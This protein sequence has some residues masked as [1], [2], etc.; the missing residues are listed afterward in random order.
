MNQ[1]YQ[2]SPIQYRKRRKQR[3]LQ[4]LFPIKKLPWFKSLWFRGV[5]LS[6]VFISLFTGLI[7]GAPATY[8][9]GQVLLGLSVFISLR[10][11]ADYPLLNPIQ[12]VIAIFYWWFGVGPMVVSSYKALVAFLED[13]H[14]AQV[15][16]IEALIIVACGLPFY[17]VGARLALVWF[18][19]KGTFARF[20][21][22]D[23]GNYKLTTIITLLLVGGISYSNSVDPRADGYC[24]RGGNHLFGRNDNYVWWVGVIA[25]VSFILWFA[26]S[27]ILT[28]LVH[29][30]R[31]TSKVMILLAGNCRF[32]IAFL[33][34]LRP[35][36]RVHFLSCFFT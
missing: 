9:V 21:M 31:H 30:G 7:T 27:S 16:A 1:A 29:L 11:L 24:R 2:F 12:A 14:Y 5:L 15:S 34:Q 20:L 28:E 19:R 4:G 26:N 6:I 33:V 35:D 18:S 25:S 3:F 23:A 32:V 10:F 22:P 13:A 17:A 36:R 8:L